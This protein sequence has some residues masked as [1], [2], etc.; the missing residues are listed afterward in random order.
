MMTRE[1]SSFRDPSGYV[2]WEDGNL[3]RKIN[4]CYQED[5]SLLISSGLYKS[6]I[7]KDLL[8]QHEGV[9]EDLIRPEVVPFISYPYE[10]SFSMWKDAAL[11]TLEVQKRAM[12]KGMVLKDASAYNIQF[13]G[14]KPLLIDTL[15]FTRYERGRPWVAYS[16]FCRHFLNPLCLMA[17]KDV[18]LGQLA[19]VYMDGIPSDLASRLLPLRTRIRPSLLGHIHAQGLGERR[20]WKKIS[21][22]MSKLSLEA[23]IDSLESTIGKLRW[24]P[25]GGWSKYRIGNSYRTEGYLHKVSTVSGYL[26]Q[27]HP[28]R[29]WDLGSNL[30]YFSRLAGKSGA[31]VVS[32]DSDPA[33]TELHYLERD[34]CLPLTVDLTNPSPGIGWENLERK[35]LIDR[36]PTDLVLALALVHHLAITNNIPLGDVARF[37]STLGR[38]LIVEFVP[39]EDPQVQR[40]L[41]SR[42]DIFVDYTEDNFRQEFGRLFRIVEESK[43]QNSSRVLFLMEVK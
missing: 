20:S 39:K 5:Y 22:K 40:L 29:V 6:L 19:R 28:R 38:S 15:S 11:V 13:V 10:W 7:G 8:I 18:R 16:Q 37:L 43:I 2:Y 25:G 30:G 32:F 41:S 14:G 4:P 3:Y 36:G 12:R 17:Y 42:D 35:S 23:L 31:N 27:V 21:P 9:R 33:C 34:G 26:G 24:E 1:T